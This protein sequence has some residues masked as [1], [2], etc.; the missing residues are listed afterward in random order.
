MR[1]KGTTTYSNLPADVPDFGYGRISEDR[2][3]GA[4]V[5]DQQ[6]DI[7]ALRERRGWSGPFL[8]FEDNDISA[9]KYA[10]SKRPEHPTACFAA[11]ATIA[12]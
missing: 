8:Y 9:S 11:R 12:G 4:G 7:V 6:A 10:R 5:G 1:G 3:N 2:Q